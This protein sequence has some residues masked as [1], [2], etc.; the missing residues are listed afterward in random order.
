MGNRT[1]RFRI[2]KI[3]MVRIKKMKRIF[4]LTFLLLSVQFSVAQTLYPELTGQALIEQLRADYKPVHVLGYDTARDTMFAVIDNHNNYVTCVYTGY[5]IYIDP[6]QDP[7]TAAYNQ[8]MNTEH[9][10]PQSKGADTGNANSDLHHLYPCRAQTNSSRGNDPFAEIN[11]NV[12]D[13]WWRLDYDQ[14]TIPTSYI[15]EY[16]EKDNNGYFEPREDHKGNAARSVFY[17]YTMYKEQSDTN[18]FN[19]QKETLRQWNLLDDVDQA[20]LDRSA[21]VATYQDGKE[22]PFVLDTTLVRRAYFTG[23]S[24]GSG[25]GGDTTATGE[26]GD[27]IITEIMQNPSAVYDSEGEWFE[28]YNTTSAA[29]DIN[30]W[31]IRDNDTDSHQIANG[32]PLLVPAQDYFVLSRNGNSATNGGVTVDYEYSGVDLGNS[33]DEIVLFAADGTTEIDRVEYD[34]GSNWSDPTGASM[35]FTGQVADNNNDY[36]NWSTSQ[37]PWDGSAGDAGSPGYGDIAA[38]IADKDLNTPVDYV[39][40]N[41]PN[42]FNPTTIINYELPITNYVELSVFNALG[43]KVRTLVHGRKAA[44]KHSVVFNADGLTGGIYFYHL[45]TNSGIFLTHKM[46]LLK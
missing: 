19:E 33:G 45:R 13:K 31:Y 18:F 35:Y 32:G 24:G 29:I 40:R 20:E 5:T 39:L 42:P 15:D 7:S 17:F 28:I 11:D 10:W 22:N 26:A 8:D 4:T 34:G 37:I 1:S 12:T 46:L 2:F 16:S 21:L 3:I 30:G 38:E 41:Y 44:G 25:S 23:S 27:I 43:Q 6:A 14:T 36:S 9:T